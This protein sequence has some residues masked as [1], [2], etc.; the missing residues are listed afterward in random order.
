MI[1]ALQRLQSIHQPSG[2]PDQMAAFGINGGVAEGMKKLFMCHPSLE[3]R[4]AA[5]REGA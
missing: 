2:L 1:A 3:A 5:L 4:I